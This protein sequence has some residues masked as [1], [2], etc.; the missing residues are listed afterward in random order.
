MYCLEIVFCDETESRFPGYIKV[1]IQA[2]LC[3]CPNLAFKII[4]QINLQIQNNIYFIQSYTPLRFFFLR[5]SFIC[6]VRNNSNDVN[7]YNIFKALV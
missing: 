7:I 1:N 6:A 5:R 3:D 2:I 4:S